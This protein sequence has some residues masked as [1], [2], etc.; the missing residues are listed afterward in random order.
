MDRVGADRRELLATA[1]LLAVGVATTPWWRLPR[2]LAATGPPLGA[3]ARELRGELVTRSSPSYRQA[4]LVYDTRYNGVRPLAIAYCEAASDVAKSIRWARRHRV[5]FTARSGGHSYGGYSTT[6]GLVIDVS[7]LGRVSL[8]AAGTVATVGAGAKLIDVYADLWQ[9]RRTLP[10]GSCPTVGIAGLA[11]GGGV[12]F[13]SRAFGTTSDNLLGVTLVDASGR[14]RTCDSG[15]SPDLYWACRGGGGGNFGI[16]TSF[17]FR[18]HPVGDVATFFVSWPWA[19]AAQVVEAWQRWAPHARDELFSVLT[20]VTSSPGPEVRIAGQFLG[21]KDELE[22]LLRPVLVGSPT[23]VTSAE[24][25]YMDA[26]M[27]WAG[28]S[29]S[30]EEC[31]LPPEGT[32]PRAAFKATSDYAA[33][34]LTPA[35]IRTMLAWIERR[36]GQSGV[37][38]LDAYGG[39]INRVP[40]G[41]TAFAHRKM[42]FSFQYGAYWSAPA[43]EGPALRWIRGFRAAMRPF[44]SGAAYVNYIDPDIADWPRAYYGANYRR[45]QAIKRRYDPENVFR[46][47]QSIRLPA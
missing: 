21:P 9:R 19:E 10:A 26:A 45:L 22:G 2:A 40:A 47:R 32:L 18:A 6:T 7:R 42:L 37:L 14:V 33:T 23:S 20:L 12:G 38:L 11:L 41:A 39:A 35:A 17:R 43:G 30:V 34:P 36:Q 4:R 8:N 16:A 46:F 28:C 44:V 1:G 27:L 5:P 31:H 24:R 29:G 25:S 3:L 15:E 13:T